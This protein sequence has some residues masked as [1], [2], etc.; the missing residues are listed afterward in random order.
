MP[1]AGLSEAAVVDAAAKIAD[2]DGLKAVTL[3]R[4]DVVERDRDLWQR[5]AEIIQA[6]HL[7]PG[8]TVVDLGSGAGYFTLK[9]S[10][11]VGKSG[12]VRAVDLRKMSLA[13]LWVRALLRNQRNITVVHGDAAD[14]SVWGPV[15]AVLVVNTYHEF[16]R[17]QAVLDRIRRSLVSGGR[18]VIA[19]RAPSLVAG[20]LRL[21]GSGHRRFRGLGDSDIVHACPVNGSSPA[22]ASA[23]PLRT[24]PLRLPSRRARRSQ[25]SATTNWP[26][27]RGI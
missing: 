14:P 11:A 23:M 25:S 15:D 9:L 1:R 27:G 4:L 17:P 22:T 6:L 2:A 13:F 12:T 5:P 10:A 20:F 19:D 16:E 7:S 18:L 26:C 24:L 8:N 21:C 3:A